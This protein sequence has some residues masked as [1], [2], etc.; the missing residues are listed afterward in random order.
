MELENMGV[1]AFSALTE[2][3]FLFLDHK[4]VTIN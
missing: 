1:T 2:N 3:K 4:A